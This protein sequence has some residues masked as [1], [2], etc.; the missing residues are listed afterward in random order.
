[1]YICVYKNEE[2]YKNKEVFKYEEVVVCESL[3][4]PNSDG[5]MQFGK[6]FDPVCV[7]KIG[8]QLSAA[9]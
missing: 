7:G 6:R 5:N 3:Y 1:M 8:L 4:F 9:I 2:V